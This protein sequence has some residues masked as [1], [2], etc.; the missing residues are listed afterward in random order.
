M[1]IT[2]KSFHILTEQEFKDELKKLMTTYQALEEKHKRE[3]APVI[4]QI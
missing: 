2:L 1:Y 3:I 4:D